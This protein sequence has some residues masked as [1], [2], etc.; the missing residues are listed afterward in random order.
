MANPSELAA[1]G[2]HESVREAVTESGRAAEGEH[3]LALPQPGYVASGSGGSLRS[4]TF[5][6]ARSSS[7]V[8][9]TIRALTISPGAALGRRGQRAV[10]IRRPQHHLNATGAVDDVGVGHDVAVGVDH[11]SRSAGLLRTDNHSTFHPGVLS[12]RAPYALTRICTTLGHTLRVN[13]SIDAFQAA[14]GSCGGVRGT[15]CA[16]AGIEDA[17]HRA[18]ALISLVGSSPEYGSGASAAFAA[19]HECRRKSTVGRGHLRYVV[20]GSPRAWRAWRA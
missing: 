9:P 14:S 3:R 2:R 20:R 13:A 15:G 17:R 19:S 6:S 5:N 8:R 12:S 16:K 4:S 7:V 10:G 11:E 18:I 1:D